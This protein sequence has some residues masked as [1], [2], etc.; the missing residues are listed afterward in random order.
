MQL[1]QSEVDHD[2]V[3]GVRLSRLTVTTKWRRDYT[4]GALGS[5]DR[6]IILTTYIRRD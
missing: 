3:A 4:L 5:D 6:T 2:D 1:T